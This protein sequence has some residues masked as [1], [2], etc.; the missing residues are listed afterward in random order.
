VIGGVMQD[1]FLASPRPPRHKT[2]PRPPARA[3][4]AA[5][6]DGRWKIEW[7]PVQCNVG[8]GT[9]VYA[10]QGSHAFFNKMQVLNTRVPVASVQIMVGGNFQPMVS[11]RCRPGPP[12]SRLQPR[13]APRLRAATA[14]LRRRRPLRAA[15]R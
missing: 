7:Q 15:D 12:G 6:G 14:T 3:D 10:F 9:F 1:Q 13:S 5:F 11:A 2:S 8:S 4:M